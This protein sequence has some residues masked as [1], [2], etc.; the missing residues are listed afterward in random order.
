MHNGL[1]LILF[2]VLL[3]NNTQAQDPRSVK[4]IN[5]DFIEK[6][7]QQDAFFQ[8]Y[9][10]NSKDYKIQIIYTEINRDDSGVVSLTHHGYNIND[11]GY[12]YPASTVKF[13]ISILAMQ[14]IK[15]LQAANKRINI[16]NGLATDAA[17]H[18][19]ETVFNDP[20]AADGKPSIA[21][22]IKKILLVSDNDANNRLFEF[23][24]VDYINKELK[25]KGFKYAEIRHRLGAPQY[26]E[27]DNKFT[28]PIS[29]LDEKGNI[30]YTQSLQKSNYKFNKR[31]DKIGVG[32]YQN[33]QL[34]NKPFDFSNKN[35][36][37]LTELHSTVQQIIFPNTID[38]LFNIDSTDRQLLLKYMSQKPTES[39]YPDYM[40]MDSKMNDGYCKFL[41]YGGEA[42]KIPDH[43]RIFNKV[44]D[45]YGFLSD[46][47]Y[48]V[49]FKNGVEFFLSATIYVNKD[50]VF[51]DDKYEYDTEGFP[52][53]KKLGE[54]IYGYELKRN[55]PILP[56]L[57]A[58]QFDYSE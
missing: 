37:T 30:T 14:K 46:A 28:N 13:P 41:L 8:P 20:T 18:N 55:K 38:K 2:F 45:A 31:T 52:F 50:G 33:N 39:K 3:M 36:F 15:E 57:S 47:A 12:Y 40:A 58:F 7:L 49:D 16:Y 5:D 6:L 35:K 56:N 43:I 4:K 48:I 11:E 44:G 32:Y 27:D 25:N 34:V 1:L 24:G 29:L 22:Y 19:Q 26:S 21:Q 23:L 51:N 54:T 17:G 10:K 42:A 53:L 9:L